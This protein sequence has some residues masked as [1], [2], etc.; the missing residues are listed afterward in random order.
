MHS[1]YKAYFHR[2]NLD[3]S[4][5]KGLVIGCPICYKRS[6]RNPKPVDI[7]CRTTACLNLK[8]GMGVK[9]MKTLNDILNGDAGA[10]KMSTDEKKAFIRM[11]LQPKR[12]R[13]VDD[14]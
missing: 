4:S 14:R 2:R 7:T 10:Q 1:Y 3:S 13:D 5:G 8:E 11:H 12:D 9:D 6:Q